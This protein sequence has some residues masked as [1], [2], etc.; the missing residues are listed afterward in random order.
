MSRLPR[1]SRTRKSIIL[2]DKSISIFLWYREHAQK[3][4]C[5]CFHRGPTPWGL[6]DTNFEDTSRKAF[7][8]CIEWRKSGEV[9]SYSALGF[10]PEVSFHSAEIHHMHIPLS[11][12]NVHQEASR[13]CTESC[14]IFHFQVKVGCKRT[15]FFLVEWSRQNLSAD[16]V[17][18][19]ARATHS[20]V[21]SRLSDQSALHFL[22]VVFSTTSFLGKQAIEMF[23]P[24]LKVLAAKYL[25]L[26]SDGMGIK[27]FLC[28][29]EK[30]TAEVF[31]C[32]APLGRSEKKN[33]WLS[34]VNFCSW[35]V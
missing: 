12:C 16:C 3:K 23:S 18:S 19:R 7:S 14:C 28:I 4:A 21:E 20:F 32:P 8:V 6:I 17:E 33:L 30:E 5:R 31:F 24:D 25:Q 1:A 26:R 2:L 34:E 11:K 35:E 15:R 27:V 22:S 10:V 13:L 29:F 9:R